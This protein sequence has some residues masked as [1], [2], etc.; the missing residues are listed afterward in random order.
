MLQVAVAGQGFG[1]AAPDDA[2]FFDDVMAVGELDQ[3]AD[4]LV[5]HQD[6]LALALQ[7]RE[8]GPDLLAQERREGAGAST[9][10]VERQDQTP[11]YLC[12][13]SLSRASSRELPVQTT[14]PFSTM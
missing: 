9:T 8:A 3:G 7:P 14:R 4:V 6:G 11:R 1:G 5:D 13:N 10:P 12:C 2:A